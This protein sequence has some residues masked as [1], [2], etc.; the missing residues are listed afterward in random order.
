[1]NTDLQVLLK[2]SWALVEDRQDRLAGWFYAYIFMHAPPVRDLFPV[3]MDVQR[4]R[5]LTAI[6]TA[7]HSLDDPLRL[8][9]YLQ[10]LGRDHRKFGT[11]PEHYTLVGE[12]LVSALRE[13]AGRRWSIQYEQAWR[14]AYQVIAQKMIAGA[15]GDPNPALWHA[16]VVAHERRTRDI[17]VLTMKPVEGPVPYLP[18]QY[19]SVE[20]PIR[21]RLWRVYSIANA[22]RADHT[23]DLHVRALGGGWVSGALV[24]R[25][26]VGLML[27]IAAP[28][29][30]MVLDPASDRDLVCVAGGTGLA[31]IKAIVEELATV[32][33]PRQVWLVFGARRRKDLYDLPALHQ[34]A[35]R[36]PWLTV[37]P[38][39]S[40]KEP[41][42]GGAEAGTAAEVMRRH[43]PWDNHDFYV[44]G[45]PGM[46]T[47]TLRAIAAM[48]VPSTRVRYDS[49]GDA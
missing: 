38:A 12:A 15:A 4:S 33:R 8:D 9:D 13:H 6:V 40:G 2:E 3:Q 39:L 30:S 48:R 19:V 42:E 14:D 17:A 31:P 25:T 11:E 45:S 7:I 24:R 16:E 43:G 10:G 44:S 20:T 23:L 22:P 37:V 5:L 47:A 28:M 36:W 32:D 46:V 41:P 29:G 27:R 49:F 18:G 35:E 34:L 26:Q 21:P 1:M